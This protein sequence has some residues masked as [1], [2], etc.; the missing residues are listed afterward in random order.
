MS[1]TELH[2][3]L[4]PLAEDLANALA[5]RDKATRRADEIKAEIRALLE[6]H[7]PGDYTAGLHTIK[8]SAARTINT[9]RVAAAYPPNVHPYL[10]DLKPST[11]KVRAHLGETQL[12]DFLDTSD[13]RIAL[14]KGTR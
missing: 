5:E 3:Q 7:G 12:E 9:D 4:E 11:A 8:A 1:T 13:L 2:T 6:T 10:Y 14:G